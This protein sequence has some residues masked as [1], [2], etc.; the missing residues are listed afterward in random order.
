[1]A[2]TPIRHAHRISKQLE[3]A[4]A[5]AGRI[6][7]G[8]QPIDLAANIASHIISLCADAG[9]LE[10]H[11]ATCDQ[12]E[13]QTATLATTIVIREI[14]RPAHAIILDAAPNDATEVGAVLTP[15]TAVPQDMTDACEA[16]TPAS[17]TAYLDN[18][19]R[20]D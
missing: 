20:E 16:I 14:A 1:M 17:T 18:E 19:H 10:L 11:A 12:A 4:S 15:D 6:T 5:A 3:A 9:R 2:D 8:D 13:S 7:E